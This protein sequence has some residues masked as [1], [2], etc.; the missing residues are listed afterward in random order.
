MWPKRRWPHARC[1]QAT[2]QRRCFEK[3]E[4]DLPSRLTRIEVGGL[5]HGRGTLTGSTPYAGDVRLDRLL[6]AALSFA[7]NLFFP[8]LSHRLRWFTRLGPGGSL[9]YVLARIGFAVSLIWFISKG[10]RQQDEMWAEV[11]GHLGREPTPDEV[12]E[13]FMNADT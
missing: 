7:G 3:D 13:Y 9:A 11:R 2:G 1:R 12:Y 8:R 5:V 4:R 6:E 10:A